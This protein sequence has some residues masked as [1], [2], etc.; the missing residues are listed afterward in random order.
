MNE[1][2][3]RTANNESEAAVETSSRLA[4]DAFYRAL[5]ATQRRRVL[6]LLSDETELTVEELATLLTGWDATETNK[7][8]TPADRE[9]TIIELVH[10][11][12]PLLAECD[13]VSYDAEN[14][15]VSIEPLSETVVDLINESI[16]VESRSPS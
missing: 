8:A 2:K 13:L 15:T 7:M 5:A 11:H 12:L 14:A 16:D 1:E 4:D 9:T 10:I 3:Q 6:S